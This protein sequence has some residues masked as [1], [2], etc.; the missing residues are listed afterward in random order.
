[1]D[2][3][4]NTVIDALAIGATF[5][6][7]EDKTR[8]AGAESYL[9]DVELSKGDHE[10]LVDL[11]NQIDKLLSTP[12][13]A[14]KDLREQEMKGIIGENRLAAL[15]DLLGEMNP[16]GKTFEFSEIWECEDKKNVV[17]PCVL[18]YQNQDWTCVFCGQPED[19]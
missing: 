3:T 18:T 5:R 17:T 4:I 7:H 12:A 14:A 15:D 1:M 10:M 2:T 19:R 6:L 8:L 13:D 9:E 16:E 11:R